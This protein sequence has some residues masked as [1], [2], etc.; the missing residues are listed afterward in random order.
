MKPIRTVRRAANAA[1][2]RSSARKTGTLRAMYKVAA[3]QQKGGV[4]KS[5]LAA[6]AS[7]ALIERGRK[8]LAVDLD[9]Q[10]HL[11]TEALGLDEAPT[12][13]DE[14]NLAN[15]LTGDY[16]GPIRDL[17]VKHSEHESGGELWVLP[18]T[19]DMFLVVR[20]LY[21]RVKK[22]EERL[23]LLLEELNNELRARGER[24]FDEAVIDCP[25]SLDVLTD[26]ALAAAD[27]IIIP[28]EPERTSI[29]A[30]RLLLGQISA[31]E[32]ELRLSTRD[33]LGLVPSRYR[34]PLAGIDKH[35]MGEFEALRESGLHIIARL[36]LAT[37]VKEAW[38]HG[39][40]VSID[41]PDVP[42]SGQ[43]RRIAA[44]IDIYAGLADVEDLDKY[45]AWPNEGTVPK[46][47]NDSV[48][49]EHEEEVVAQ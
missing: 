11:T 26:N 35:V 36:P 8:V 19:L 13:P 27:G 48:E 47:L 29:R 14:A 32:E 45:P 17:L 37:K 12:G 42:I 2:S 41:A 33:L 4:G 34:R 9:P 22:M 28:V 40:P 7:G 30:L 24:P 15:A 31:V 44:V 39:V 6:G 3:L 25:P 1:K 23:A 49:G 10:G 46:S 20:Q 5:A 43:Y 21:A 16:K 18:T 38:L